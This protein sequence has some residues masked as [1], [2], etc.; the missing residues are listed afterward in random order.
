MLHRLGVY[1]DP[2][3][4]QTIS[5]DFSVLGNVKFEA[6]LES[7]Y[8][9]SPSQYNFQLAPSKIQGIYKKTLQ[10]DSREPGVST[11]E[12][13]KRPDDRNMP[14]LAQEESGHTITDKERLERMRDVCTMDRSELIAYVKSMGW[15]IR[16]SIS[17]AIR[18]R[19]TLIPS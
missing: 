4:L 2:I 18:H 1:T 17:C 14:P 19:Y 10:I 13:T 16:M 8:K 7:V 5:P 3:A 9:F 12:A 6:D 11:D 15:E